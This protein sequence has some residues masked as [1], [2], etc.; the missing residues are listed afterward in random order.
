MSQTAYTQDPAIAVPGLLVDPGHSN[1]IISK[2]LTDASLSFGLAVT[3]DVG[4]T[5]EEARAPTATGEVT[6]GAFFGVAL[7]DVTI[8]Q[9][10]TPLGWTI[11]DTLRV[12][13]W[14]RVW[15]LAEDVVATIGLPAFVRFV[16]AG[17]EE[18]GAFR[19]DADTADAVAL[20]GATFRTTT[21]AVN[22]LVQ[23]ELAPTA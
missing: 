14:G 10:A 2:F 22:Q 6:G 3:H 15:V 5:D 7:N 19:T 11:G 21:S 23:L 4:T 18:L 8:E 17:A 9:A 1:F 20:P 13:R 16:A 12:L